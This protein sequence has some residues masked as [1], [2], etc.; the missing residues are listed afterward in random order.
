MRLPAGVQGQDPRP[1]LG[2]LFGATETFEQDHAVAAQA[3]IVRR[4]GDGPVDE[5]QPLGVAAGPEADQGRLRPDQGILR[6]A[7][8]ALAQGQGQGHRVR[9]I[10]DG[11]PG[12]SRAV[13]V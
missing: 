1:F 10:A 4:Q 2:R 3:R 13:A 5:Q 7:D 9:G 12:I 6:E 11:G 8:P